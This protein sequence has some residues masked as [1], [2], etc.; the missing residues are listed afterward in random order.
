MPST[1]WDRM[2]AWRDER[3]GDD[4][5]LWH[6]AIILPSMY[7]VIGPVRGARVLDV[8]CGVGVLARRLARGGA[9]Q[10]VGV[11]RS[12]PTIRRARARERRDPT[13]ARFAVRDAR[14][15]VGFADRSFDLVVANMSLMDIEHADEAVA[16]AARVL[17][18]HGR[19]VFSLCHPCFDTNLNSHWSVERLLQPRG[20]YEDVVY[21]KVSRYRREVRQK[22]PWFV[23]PRRT[24]FTDGFHR[25]LATYSR[26]LRAAGLVIRRLE[27]P[28][29]Q[30]EAVEKS[31]QG[32]WMLEIPLHLVVEA[33]RAAPS[34]TPASRR[35]GGSR[36]A[37]D[38]RS[39]SS[40]R[41]RG[42][43]SRRRGSTPGS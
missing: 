6:R 7:E 4:G 18:P 25:T 19:F 8:G 20:G 2:A 10:V 35:S 23:S 43:G 37:G 14:R 29:P 15:L 17:R 36:R 32:R 31:P 34:A 3:A 26:Y 38:R 13:G 33:V 16:E 21:R 12:A 9:A 41:T 42:T 30:P 22:V 24:V 27:E 40:R 28:V 11:D 39:G 5:D 1:G